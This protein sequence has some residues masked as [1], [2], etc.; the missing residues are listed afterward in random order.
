MSRPIKFGQKKTTMNISIHPTLKAWIDEHC[1]ENHLT[2]SAFLQ[3]TFLEK[4]GLEERDLIADVLPAA[5]RQRVQ[6]FVKQRDSN[7][8][9]M[10]HND[11]EYETEPE[12]LDDQGRP[13]IKGMPFEEY[14]AMIQDRI[15]KGLPPLE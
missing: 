2:F 12:Q 10:Q 3:D 13:Y 5:D 1:H 14:R 9:P 7:V 15:K 6:D 4:F 11:E 8:I